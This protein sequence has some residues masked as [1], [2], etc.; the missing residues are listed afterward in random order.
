MTE[1]VLLHDIQT[2]KY[3]DVLGNKDEPFFISKRHPP[4]YRPHRFS[5]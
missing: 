2:Y 1:A 3:V 4:E 5:T